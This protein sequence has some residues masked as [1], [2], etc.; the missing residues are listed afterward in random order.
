MLVFNFSRR[1]AW[2]GAGGDFYKEEGIWEG[3]LGGV[4]KLLRALPHRFLYLLNL[5][6]ILNLLSQRLINK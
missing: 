4:G 2:E 5:L 6:N 1:G 3:D